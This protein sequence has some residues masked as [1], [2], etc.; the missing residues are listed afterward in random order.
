MPMGTTFAE[1][2]TQWAMQTIDDVTWTQSL[3]ENPAA[4]FR[5]KSDTLIASLGH[6]SRPPE[7]KQW[8]TFTAPSYANWTHTAAHELTLP[9]GLSTGITGMELCCCT[10]I[11]T[12]NVQS[13]YTTLPVT[14]DAE[15][16]EVTIPETAPV[17]TI[18]EGAVLDFDFY[19]DG[20]FDRDLDVEQKHILGLCVALQWY[21]RFANTWLNIQPKIKDRSFDTVSESA[22][23]TAA[24]TKAKEMR[25]A[26]NDALLRYEENVYYR[27]RMP[28]MQKLNPPD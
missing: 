9:V 1:I 12:N 28:M 13:T 23:I 20:V 18:P 4:F 10:M 2:I 8:L 16:G 21:T 3:A 15:T 26:L 27:Q 5:A 14:Y 24:A 17:A 25:L 6:F 19:K 11:T 7:I 22:H